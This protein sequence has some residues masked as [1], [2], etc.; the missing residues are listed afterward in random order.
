MLFCIAHLLDHIDGSAATKYY[1][2]MMQNITNSYLDKTLDPLERVEKI[3]YANFFVRY[4]RQ[5]IIF[6][7][8]LHLNVTL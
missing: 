1:L 5:W 8:S 6:I 3:W 7:L 2:E 4:W